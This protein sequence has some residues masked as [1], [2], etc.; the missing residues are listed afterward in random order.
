MMMASSKLAQIVSID[1]IALICCVRRNDYLVRTN[2]TIAKNNSNDCNFI[3]SYTSSTAKQNFG[4]HLIVII[5]MTQI[6]I[7][8]W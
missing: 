2:T 5:T 1:F 3:R 7:Y 8:V 6:Y 4:L